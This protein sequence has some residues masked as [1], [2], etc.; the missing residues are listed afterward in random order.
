MTNNDNNSYTSIVTD[1]KFKCP[2]GKC[3]SSLSFR[4]FFDDPCCPTVRTEFQDL[5]KMM[6]LLEIS[7][8]KDNKA[9][10]EMDLK[11][12]RFQ[13]ATLL[14]NEKKEK[15]DKSRKDLAST[16]AHAEIVLENFNGDEKSEFHELKKRIINSLNQHE[17][18]E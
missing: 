1:A 17:I 18:F 2:E 3:N 4:K 12:K 11:E 13:D 10:R 16:F 7:E 5:T 8:N 9:K 15:L 6:K 14:L